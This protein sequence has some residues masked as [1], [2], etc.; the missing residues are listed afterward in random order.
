MRTCS[1]NPQHCSKNTMDMIDIS[2]KILKHARK[3][4]QFPT[5]S[6]PSL[7]FKASRGK[8]I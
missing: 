8:N 3:Y 1:K 7:L 4:K 2:E 5:K 6:A